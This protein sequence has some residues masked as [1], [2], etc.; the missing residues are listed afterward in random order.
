MREYDQQVYAE[1]VTVLRDFR[2]HSRP[3]ACS[4]LMQK[5]STRRIVQPTMGG[6]ARKL[7]KL[8]KSGWGEAG[9]VASGCASVVKA[10]ADRTPPSWCCSCVCWGVL[11]GGTTKYLKRFPSTFRVE[12]DS[13]MLVAK[14][15]P[16]W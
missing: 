14:Y 9:C 5:L 4:M 2:A 15:P 3:V 10:G 16:K 7:S 12:D 8:I 11:T 6:Q 1:L 13:V